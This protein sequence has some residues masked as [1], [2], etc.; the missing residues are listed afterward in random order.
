MIR[1]IILTLLA[2]SCSHLGA[3]ERRPNFLIILADNL[4]K[5]WV[6]C[7]GGDGGH[8]PNIDRLAADGV[9]FANCYVTPMCS[10]TRVEFLTGRYA[11]RTGWHTHHDA[12]HY[13]GGGLDWRRETTWARVL[14]DAGYATC[15]T[16]KWQI[17]DLY[18]QRDAL[19]QHG[20]D[21][22]LVWTGA[23]VG[24]GLAEQRWKAT[25]APGGK[26][27]IESR[28][29]DP[30]VFRNGEHAKLEGK[31]GPD[32]FA[33]YLVEFMARNREKPFVAFYS[34]PLTHI[35]PVPTPL[36]PNRNAPDL[37]KFAGMVRYADTQVGRFE[38]EL[39]RL[40]L[41]DD[42]IVIFMTDNG[43]SVKVGGSIGG[44]PVKGGLG[45]MSESG[46]NVP[47]VVNCPAR[48]AKGRVGKTLVDCSD[49]FPTLLELASVPLPSGLTIDGRSLGAHLDPKTEPVGGRDW[50][51][52]QYAGT[53]VIRDHRFKLYSTGAIFDLES[54]PLEKKDLNRSSDTAVVA[55]KGRLQQALDGL[56]ADADVG[57]EFRSG[58]A[59][60]IK[61]RAAR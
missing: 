3:A 55:A 1:F 40:G 32:V 6:G 33:D 2:V 44:K 31:F 38:S 15:I 34:C 42:T 14:R 13:G 47:L 58:S 25:L 53:R 23:F 37:E 41:R 24:E 54:D 20:F 35:P 39:A 50:I 36:T 4:G 61:K 59:F 56:P 29:W 18:D 28:Y 27:E 26:R 22:H 8:T 52:T 7:Y 9:R 11:F 19:K 21:E 10:T 60:N 43:T 46:L 17:N 49:I 5:D 16:G 30:V 57:F 51:F 48:V 12:G 45:T